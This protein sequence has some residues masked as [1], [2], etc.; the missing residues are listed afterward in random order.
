MSSPPLHI[1]VLLSEV[2]ENLQL[3][4]GD[5]VVDA[6]LGLGGHSL[7]MLQI[8]G[9]QGKLIGFDADPR[10]LDIA[11]AKF[12]KFP[13]VRLIQANFREMGNFLSADSVDAILMDIGMS[14]L[15]FDDASR[16]FSFQ[17]EGNLDMRLN[18]SQP[19]SAKEIVN[20]WSE[21][22]L[23]KILRE[24]GEIH[25]SAKVA[26][27]IITAR[28]AKPLETTLDLAAAVEAKTLL[29]Q[30]FQALR[31]AVNDELAALQ[32]GLAAAVKL[33]KPDGRIAVIS[34]HS[35]EDR[36]VKN[37]FRENTKRCICPPE[38]L[39]CDCNHSPLLKIITKK[40]IKPSKEEIQK[41]PRSR[42]ALLRIAEKL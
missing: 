2:L 9:S 30:V 12:Q 1:P 3:K 24:Y 7:E 29:P 26:R 37:F 11:T 22:N 31:I 13:N 17:R 36:I 19:F 6:T 20:G 25:T 4:V 15:H 33:L 32:E 42:S 23:M 18:Q 35:L 27:G 41:N 28:K 5:T 34:F 39:K 40:P 8:I 16:G 21:N 38:K 10:N 14:S